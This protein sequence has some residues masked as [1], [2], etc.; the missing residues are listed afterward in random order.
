VAEECHVADGYQVLLIGKQRA[1][2]GK[3][4]FER[5]PSGRRPRSRKGDP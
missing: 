3:Q 4:N 2:E 5:L 1:L